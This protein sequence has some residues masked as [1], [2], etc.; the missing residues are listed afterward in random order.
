[1]LA[2]D[3]ASVPASHRVLIHSQPA[4]VFTANRAPSI[5]T[6]CR[7]DVNVVVK[8]IEVAQDELVHAVLW[9][10]VT[11]WREFRIKFKDWSTA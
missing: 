9:A 1:M 2:I 11:G 8:R 3:K 6:C 4:L 5:H 10:M 7:K